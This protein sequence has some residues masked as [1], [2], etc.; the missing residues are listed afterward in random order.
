[1]TRSLTRA[2]TPSASGVAEGAGVTHECSCG[3]SKRVPTRE[4]WK[5]LGRQ[6]HWGHVFLV[7]TLTGNPRGRNWIGK[8]FV[9]WVK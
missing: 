2:P 7:W 3:L 6:T 4:Q 1:M 5:F 9:R 8:R